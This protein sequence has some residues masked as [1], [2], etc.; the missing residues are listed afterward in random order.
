MNST[1]AVINHVALVLDGSG[2]MGHLSRQVVAAADGYVAH[3]ARRSKEQNQETRVSVYV[4]ENRDQIHCHVFDRDVLR[5]PSIAGLYRAHGNTPLIDATLLAIRELQT[6]STLHGDHSF[7]VIVLTDGEENA[8]RSKGSQLNT[9]LGMLPD[10]WTVACFVPDIMGKREAKQFGFPDENIAIWDASSAHGVAEF[11]E[12]LNTVTDNYMTARSTG[13]RGTRN[14]FSMDLKNLNA[15]TVQNLS[16]L[17]PGQFR[18]YAVHSDEPIAKFVERVTGRPY[19]IGEGY[20]Q[21]SKPVD[22]QGYKGV[23][24]L[25][26]RE[27]TVYTGEGARRALGLP[28]HQVRLAPN[29]HPDFDIFIQSTSVNRKLLAG[30]SLLLISP[31]AH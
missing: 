29:S 11:S 8:S 3:L 22:V 4:F 1:Q 5:L 21:L 13:V 7:L 27:H 19:T 14:L 2:S 26:R 20:Y 28:D 23:A 31:V 25:N 18:H 24:I 30:T 17:A 15:Q 6:T 10:N 12:K 9:T 16:K